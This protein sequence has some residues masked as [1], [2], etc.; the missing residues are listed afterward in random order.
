LIVITTTTID[1]AYDPLYRLIAADYD[2]G[3]F[4]H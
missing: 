4:F 2:S 3:Q 1:Y